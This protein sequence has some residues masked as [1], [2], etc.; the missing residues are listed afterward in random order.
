M[1][2][3][4]GRVTYSD[5]VCRGYSYARMLII[6]SYGVYIFSNGE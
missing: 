4:D 2:C 6:A 5:F 3:V 1:I